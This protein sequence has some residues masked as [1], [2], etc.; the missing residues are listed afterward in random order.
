[1]SMRIESYVYI[2]CFL[3]HSAQK[4]CTPNVYVVNSNQ[5]L[6]MMK[7]YMKRL[8]WQC[9]MIQLQEVPLSELKCKQDHIPE[10]TVQ[11]LLSSKCEV[12][13]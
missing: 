13:K 10:S 9:G 6:W 12:E 3:F 8:S 7:L 2:F 11:I 1:M 5:E 4:C